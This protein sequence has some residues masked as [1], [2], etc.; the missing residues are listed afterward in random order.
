MNKPA[1]LISLVRRSTQYSNSI[2]IHN[3]RNYSCIKQCSQ[4]HSAALVPSEI[5]SQFQKPLL[6]FARNY[7]KGK[8]I[9]KEKSKG[10]VQINEAQLAEIVNL[11]SIKKQM[12]K[13][14][15]VLKDDFV[16]NLSLRST[17]GNYYYMVQNTVKQVI[18]P[19]NRVH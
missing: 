5:K 18:F 15:E 9:R 2:F 14:I 13:A 8:N 1:V 7:A 19:V 10:K 6:Q 11:D 16:K 17:T 3:L 4:L 12:E